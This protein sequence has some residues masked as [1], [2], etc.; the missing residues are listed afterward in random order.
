MLLIAYCSINFLTGRDVI[1]DKNIQAKAFLL[2]KR[3]LV[4]DKNAFFVD[5]ALIRL[6]KV[7]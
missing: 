7:Q 4:T 3:Y 6:G 1:Q 5:E 2:K